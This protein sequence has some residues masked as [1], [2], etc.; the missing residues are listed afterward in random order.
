MIT[1]FR[2]PPIVFGNDEHSVRIASRSARA[3]GRIWVSIAERK[4]FANKLGHQ[5]DNQ[6]FYII[7]T[8]KQ[9]A[10]SQY[11][12][13][14]VWP[15]Q[16]GFTDEARFDPSFRRSWFEYQ[17]MSKLIDLW[18]RQALVRH[19]TRITRKANRPSQSILLERQVASRRRG[20]GN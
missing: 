4:P 3:D 16:K 20:R 18:V 2:N 13:P 17:P 15:Q 11:A 14:L 10:I 7:S 6:T 12:P 19:M 8:R 5:F 9:Y 1:I